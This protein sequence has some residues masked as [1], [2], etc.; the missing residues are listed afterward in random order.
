MIQASSVG[1]SYDYLSTSS[2]TSNTLYPAKTTQGKMGS[3]NAVSTQE[4]Q[5][6]SFLTQRTALGDANARVQTSG[7]GDVMEISKKGMNLSM[8]A[9][10]GSATAAAGASGAAAKTQGGSSAANTSQ[11]TAGQSGLSASGGTASASGTA[12]S[13]TENTTDLSSYSAYQLSQMLTKGTITTAQYIAEI[14]RRDDAANAGKT[15][16]SAETKAK[17]QKEADLSSVESLATAT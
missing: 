8:A 5:N 6:S 4:T 2:L 3:T 15:D 13:T 9:G 17:Q 1:S 14:K 10:T 16:E 11:A 7:D 12:T